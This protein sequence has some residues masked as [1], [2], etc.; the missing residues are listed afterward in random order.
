MTKEPK[1]KRCPQCREVRLIIHERYEFIKQF[2]ILDGSVIG[3]STGDIIGVDL[4]CM[5]CGHR[6]TP[7]GAVQSTDFA[8]ERWLTP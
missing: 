6:W 5:R 8:T 7:R 2:D 4:E 3:N 1:P